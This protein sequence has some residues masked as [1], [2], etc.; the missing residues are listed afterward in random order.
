MLA[1]YVLSYWMQRR[2]FGLA[3]DAAS[4][5]ALTVS[6]PNYTAA[7]LPLTVAVF[8]ASHAAFVA[9]AIASGSILVTPITL[10]ILEASRS[11]PGDRSG[12]SLI[13]RVVGRSLLKP[14][15][16]SPIVGITF[17]FLAIPPPDFV[18]NALTLIGQAQPVSRPFSPG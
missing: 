16:L 1:L 2:L 12:M 3:P 4:V 11:V 7:G 10:A 17:S 8:G 15:V 14:V 18:A 9:L 6:F 5:Q 13:L